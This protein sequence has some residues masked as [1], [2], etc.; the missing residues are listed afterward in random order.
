MGHAFNEALL[1]QD[2]FAV[3]ELF[4]QSSCWRNQLGP[5]WDYHSLSGP[6]KIASSLE[7]APK[8]SRIT[9]LKTDDSNASRKPSLAAADFKRKVN[10]AITLPE[11]FTTT[12]T[13]LPLSSALLW[14]SKNGFDA[15]VGGMYEEGDPETE[16]IDIMFMS[17]PK[18]TPKRMHQDAATKITKRDEAMLKGLIEAGFKLD[19]GT[20][21][22]GFFM[23][24]FQ[25][26]RGYC[27]DVGCSQLIVHGKIKVKQ[28][29]RN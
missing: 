5:W 14:F 20:D 3:K 1:A 23:K 19:D 18:G 11:D 15:L 25:R 29:I 7:S 6:R 10:G 4:L 22:A 28:E 27:I 24:Y 13:T 9:S 8:G 26:G 12:A 2:P 17:I 21:D 16:D